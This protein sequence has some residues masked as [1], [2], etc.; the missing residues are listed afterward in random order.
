MYFEKNLGDILN[1]TNYFDDVCII[2][3][4]GYIVFL[5]TKYPQHYG[6]DPQSCIGKHL[7]DVYAQGESGGSMYEVLKTG[8]PIVSAPGAIR[9]KNGK[10][11]PALSTLFRS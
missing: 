10:A 1:A 9:I 6:F 4:D 8:I 7:L 5:E 3:R 2:N 11:L